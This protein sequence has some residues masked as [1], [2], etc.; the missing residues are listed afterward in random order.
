M[1]RAILVLNSGSSSLKFGVFVMRDGDEHAWLSGSAKGI[2]RENGSL[3]I[4]SDDGAIHIAQ[5]HVMESQHDALQRIADLLREHMHE[6]LAAVGHRVVHGG[7]HLRE[8]CEITPEV[9]E[10][11]HEATPFA[12]LHL[13]ASLALIDEARVIFSD[14][15][16]FACFDT[17]FH[18]TLPEVAA[19]FALPSEYAER[20]V[21]RY[22]FHG[23]SYESIVN[24]LGDELPSRAV[25]AHLGSGAS[26]CALRDGCSVDTSMG[27]TP[28][29]GI[30]MAT[31]SGDLDPGVMVH[32]LRNESLDAGAFEALV[33]K[34]CGLKALSSSDDDMPALLARRAQGDVE[35]T[36]AVDVFCMAVRKVIGA[37]AAVLGGVELIV[38]TG[39]IG[40]HSDEV[41]TQVLDGLGFLRAQHRV[42]ATEEERQIARHCRRLLNKK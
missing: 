30:P 11:L 10:T 28:A 17:V 16:H 6:P 7:P 18:R 33:N 24:A 23:L 25:I 2:G 20:G 41:R 21:V 42:V 19:R 1:T 14:V 4:R 15:P 13:P 39:G 26:L 38:F 5:D 34:H 35:A 3:S 31:R 29:G 36:L 40:E 12:P 27:M 37:Y 8:H 9:E 22:G 32:L